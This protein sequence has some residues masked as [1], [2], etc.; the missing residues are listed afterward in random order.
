MVALFSATS[1]PHGCCNIIMFHNDDV[2]ERSGNDGRQHGD[3]APKGL[4]EW[5]CL[6]PGPVQGAG[7]EGDA[8]DGDVW[9]G[10]GAVCL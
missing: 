9:V 6:A 8:G 7:L 4:K 10:G 3:M 5:P 2:L 1:C